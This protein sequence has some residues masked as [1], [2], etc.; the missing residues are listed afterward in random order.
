MN[1][2][3][4]NAGD[5]TGR[6][7]SFWMGIPPNFHGFHGCEMPKKTKKTGLMAQLLLGEDRHWR[8]MPWS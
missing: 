1:G 8:R 4:Q 6:R 2:W 7:S 5:I 3:N